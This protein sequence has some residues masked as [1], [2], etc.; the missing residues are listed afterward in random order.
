LV[1]Q[2]IDKLRSQFDEADKV[3]RFPV[4]STFDLQHEIGILINICEYRLQDG[5]GYIDS[6]EASA[7]FARYCGGS[8]ESEIRSI[9]ENVRNQLDS[10][11]NGRISFEEYAFRFG[12][13]LQVLFPPFLSTHTIVA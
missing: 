9:S 7:L 8:S 4:A 1:L 6:E 2:V 5:S 11:R 10:D 3:T 13:K 12:R